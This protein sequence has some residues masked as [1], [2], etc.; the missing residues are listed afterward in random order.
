MS[1]SIRITPEMKG[2]YVYVSS[3][4]SRRGYVN[5]RD[6]KG[7]DR[8]YLVYPI[9]TPLLPG[10]RL[11][12]LLTW[13]AR[14]LHGSY[15]TWMFKPEITGLQT[16]PTTEVVGPDIGMLTLRQPFVYPNPTEYL[17]DVPDASHTAGVSD[18]GGFWAFV[19]GAFT[20]LFGANV[21][22]FALGH[23]PLSALGLA[24]LFQR[25]ALVRRWHE[26]F[27]TIHTEG[28]LPGSELAGIVAFIRERLVDVGE[29]PRATEDDQEHREATD[30]H[31]PS[32]IQSLSTEESLALT[33]TPPSANP[34]SSA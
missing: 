29:E 9:P 32:T 6:E 3:W 1:I 10:S 4:Y 5:L 23:R 12:G 18:L 22:Y 26:D 8:P 2:V 30:L 20:L 21:V 7:V 16:D 15:S 27:P 19:D 24:H 17:Q 14:L 34:A 28:G 33:P 31:C 13:K 11:F 25:R